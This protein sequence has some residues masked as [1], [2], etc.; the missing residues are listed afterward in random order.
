VR[1]RAVQFQSKNNSFCQK[2]RQKSDKLTN[3]LKKMLAIRQNYSANNIFSAEF[4]IWVTFFPK[5]GVL[6][7]K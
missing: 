5:P 1:K 4:Y 3:H 2:K 6:I 7:E